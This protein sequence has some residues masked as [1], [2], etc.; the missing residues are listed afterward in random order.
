MCGVAV[1]RVQIKFQLGVL[2]HPNVSSEDGTPCGDLFKG[3]GPT[4][5][6]AYLAQILVDFLATPNVGTPCRCRL[7]V[8][9]ITK[10]GAC[11]GVGRACK[12]QLYVVVVVATEHPMD[13]EL[14][15]LM[16]TDLPRYEAEARRM[17]LGG[18]RK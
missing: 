2:Y 18:G 4:K 7:L 10:G 16:T 6:V 17:A 12:C 13:E 5:N 1:A 3:F 14:V 9:G 8:V 15:R 11:A